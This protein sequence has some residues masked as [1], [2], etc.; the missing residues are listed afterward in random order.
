VFSAFERFA[1]IFIANKDIL[2][3]LENHPDITWL[4]VTDPITL[5]PPPLTPKVAALAPQ[6]ENI[7]KGGLNNLKGKG[8]IIAIVDTGLDFQNANFITFDARNQ[9]SSRLLYFWDTTSQDF[10]TKKVGHE[11]PVVYPDKRSIGTVYDNKDLT[12]ELRAKAPRLVEMDKDGHGTA[13]AGIAA[14]NGNSQQGKYLGVA[15]EADLI[16]VRIANEHDLDNGYLLGAICDWLDEK[17]KSEGK[18]LVISC[19]FGGQDGGRD[20]YRVVERRLN[21]RFTDNTQ[22]RAICIAAGNEGLL[23]FHAEATF[24]GRDAPG[25]LTWHSPQGGVLQIY[26][27]TNN[28]KDL[29]ISPLE[30]EMKSRAYLHRL[31]DAIVLEI[32]LP[33]R[34]ASGDW[35][36]QIFNDSNTPMQ[37]DAYLS[38]PRTTRFT[39]TCVKRSKQIAW[40]GAASQ[41][42]TVGSYD[43]DYRFDGIPDA[44]GIQD[45]NGA[46]VPLKV[47]IVS[48]FSNPGPLRA[49]RPDEKVVFKPEVVAPGRYFTAVSVAAT[50]KERRDPSGK[51]QLFAGT[52]AATPYTAGIVALMLQK[53]PSLTIA[54]I[55]DF[56][57]SKAT[58]DD[59]TRL[60]DSKKVPN[61]EYGY[62]KLDVD[63]VRAILRAIGEMQAKP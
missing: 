59:Q 32:D 60:V 41:A 1:D 33:S 4:D 42:I 46:E 5:P 36:L 2:S 10:D 22:G 38:G 9:P 56:L 57:T 44:F 61:P 21:A 29:R 50:P 11:A 52:S 35:A 12:A 62:G 15:P 26:Y 47:G 17:A 58:K 19:S 53:R 54:Q 34:L 14:G 6:H 48:N 24:R 27:H 23:P 45:V 30:P 18:P 55:K 13:C 7:I 16:A 20:G 31:T 43:F 8:V 40:P 63:A 51:Y 49:R 25:T 37:A 28:L 3:E 39:G